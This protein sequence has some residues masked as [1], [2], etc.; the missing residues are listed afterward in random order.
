MTYLFEHEIDS[1]IFKNDLE[2]TRKSLKLRNGNLVEITDAGDFVKMCLEKQPEKEIRTK[3]RGTK[4]RDE[5]NKREGVNGDGSVYF[6]KPPSPGMCMMIMTIFS[7]IASGSA[8]SVELIKQVAILNGKRVSDPRF[9]DNV[10]LLEVEDDFQESVSYN[11]V[12][13][14]RIGNTTSLNCFDFRC[15]ISDSKRN[16]DIINPRNRRE[17]M[18]NQNLFYN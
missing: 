2:N 10:E 9:K 4:K 6:K 15:R 1:A 18:S 13:S 11:V 14:F 12:I 3:A 17:Q 7:Y 8:N 16:H 5:K